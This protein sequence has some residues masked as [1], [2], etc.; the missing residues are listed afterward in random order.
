[1][2]SCLR[3]AVLIPV[4]FALTG[5]AFCQGIATGNLP[6]VPR[7]K[8][9]GVPFR[10]SF[11]DVTREAGLTAKFVQGDPA[12]KKYIVEANGTG[13]A[14]IDYDNDGRL[15]VFLVNGSRLEPFPKGQEPVSHLYRNTGSGKFTDVSA[16]A[17][18]TRPGW[19]NGVCA[20][21]FD[22]DGNEDLFVTYWGPNS[23]YR[24]NGKGSFEDVAVQ[25]GVAGPNDE[26][27]TGCS[28]LDYDRDGKLDLIVAS[29]V[30]FD[31]KTT[32]LPG[33]HPYCMFRDKPVFCGPRGL[34]HGMVTL[35]HNHGDGTF[36]DVSAASGVRKPEGF[37]AFTVAAADLNAD[38][39]VDVYIA[40]DSTPSLFFRNNRDGTFTE[41][42]TEAG[43]AYNENGTEQAGMGV[44]IADYD[45]DGGIDVTKTNFS[46]DYPNLYRSAG[47][48]FF[49]DRSVTAGLA[50]NPGYLL[51]GVGLEDLDNDGLR[52]V[53]QVAGHV[54]TGISAISPGLSYASPRLVYRQLPGGKFED[55]SALAGPG[56]AASHSSRGAAFG[57]FDNDGDVD[58]LIMNMDEPPSLLRND[59]QGDHRWIA[60]K[61]RGITSNRSAIGAVVELKAGGFSQ[62]ASVLSQSSYLSVNDGR[63][64]FG[65]GAAEKID[66]IVVHWPSGGVEQFS[67]A[68]PNS[69][70]LLTEGKGMAERVE[71][72]K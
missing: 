72:V 42:A 46:E 50:V 11:T 18:I 58:V 65:L 51:W 5:I 37:Y 2:L 34:P 39:W 28:F 4:S 55:V 31:P 59:L 45:N 27:T 68:S 32:P 57:D 56:V 64:H 12:R 22:N 60:V 41:L 13:V 29:Y 25:A 69:L 15:D 48:G 47:K 63:L 19:G 71:L 10:A 26:W 14:F 30:A 54:Y 35:Y 62:K 70:V 33:A 6:A 16:A 53:F 40:C 24:N 17:G 66:S 38:G 20:G 21:D 43:I 61:L 3:F 36:V 23:L 1:M 7:A 44:A 9:S 67:G 8:S 52:D 49:E